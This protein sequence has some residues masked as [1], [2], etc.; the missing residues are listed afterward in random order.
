[1]LAAFLLAGHCLGAVAI[2]CIELDLLV[3]G[4]LWVS[5][6]GSALTGVDRLALKRTCNAVTELVLLTNGRIVLVHL[7]GLAVEADVLVRTFVSPWLIILSTRTD[8]MDETQVLVRDSLG[9][10][11][12]RQLSIW[13]RHLPAR[14]ASTSRLRV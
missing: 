2:F 13:L 5:I 1:M 8:R 14:K 9:K 10:E 7:D 4:V 3:K 6:S 11:G 12:Y